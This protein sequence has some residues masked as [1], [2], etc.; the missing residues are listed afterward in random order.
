MET[1]IHMMGYYVMFLAID[2]KRESKI[3][4]FTKDWLIIFVYILISSALIK[5][6]K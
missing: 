6:T 1:I 3:K 2:Y 4:L 5:Y